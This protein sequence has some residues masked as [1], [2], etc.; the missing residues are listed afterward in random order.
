MDTNFFKRLYQKHIT[1]QA[2]KYWIKF[3]F[4]IGSAKEPNII[5]FNLDAPVLAYQKHDHNLC[6]FSRL[7]YTFVVSE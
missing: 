2:D 5:E 1:G 7:A 6:C 3:Y 4:P